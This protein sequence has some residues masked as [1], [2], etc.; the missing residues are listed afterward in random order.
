MPGCD[1]SS[2]LFCEAAAA[3]AVAVPSA[4][5]SSVLRSPCRCIVSDSVV[6][7]VQITPV[8][9]VQWPVQRRSGAAEPATTG[10]AALNRVCEWNAAFSLWSELQARPTQMRAAA[11]LCPDSGAQVQPNLSQRL[12]GVCLLRVLQKCSMLS[13]ARVEPVKPPEAKPEPRPAAPVPAAPA[14][15]VPQPARPAPAQPAQHLMRTAL[16]IGRHRR[17]HTTFAVHCTFC[18]ASRVKAMEMQNAIFRR[19][20]RRPCLR[21]SSFC[22]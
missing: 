21:C 5:D 9:P 4:P 1:E 17:V 12:Q 6:P 18:P 2:D 16:D 20:P 7:G 11:N 10:G 22:L 15:A 8:V 13:S 19:G 14:P 3:A